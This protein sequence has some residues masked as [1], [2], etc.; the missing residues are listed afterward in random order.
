ML[1]IGI[2]GATWNVIKLNMEALPNIHQLMEEGSYATITLIQKPWSPSVW[3]SMFSGQS[4]EEH[5][6]KDFVQNGRIV[7]CE[8]I[9]V[10]F[11]WDLLDKNGISV[12]ALNIPWEQ[13]LENTPERA[14]RAHDK[15][16]IMQRLRDWGYI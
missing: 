10:E 13:D 14:G 11:I 8:D 3:C 6:H 16:A 15:E 2:D 12:K 5:G 7:R 4:P 9:K 1:V